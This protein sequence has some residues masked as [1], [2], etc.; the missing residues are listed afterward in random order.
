MGSRKKQTVGYRYY[1]G[2]HMGLARG[3]VDE[4]VQIRVG[5][6]L[7]W[8]GSASGNTT[9]QINRPELFGGD[10]REGGIQGSLDVL[11]GAPA[12]PV[13]AGLAAMLGGLVPAFRGVATLFYDGLVCSG[14]PYP[15]QW[16]VRLR[17]TTAGWAGNAP[18]YTAK[19]VVNLSGSEIAAGDGRVQAIRAA[20]PAHIL[21]ECLTNPDWGRGLPAARL[22][23]TAFRA[24]ADT[25]YAEG[26]GLCLRW[27]RSDKLAAFVQEILDTI[28]GI[29][30]VDR[31]SGLVQIR[32]IRSDYTPAALPLFTPDTGLLAITEDDAGAAADAANEVIVTYHSPVDNADHQVRVRSLGA[33]QAAGGRKSA[34]SQEYQGIPTAAL[35]LRVAQRDL[36]ANSG[37]LKRFKVQ[38]DRRAF[39]VQVGD[40]FRL[41][42]PARGINNMVVRAGRVEYADGTEGTITITALQDAF[43]LPATS[44]VTPQPGAAAGPN[45]APAPVTQQ[46]LIELPYRELVQAMDG[47]NLALLSA[48][49]GYLGC[50]AA[51]PTSMSM[52]YRLLTR[53]GASGPYTDRAEAP[54][55]PTGTLATAMPL[56]AAAITVTLAGG[57][58]LDQ[59][60]P[61]TA[62]L[63]DD[64]IL[65]VDSI[66]PSAGL[67]T[68]ARGCADTVPA[69]HA[70]GARVWFYDDFAG[71]DPNEYTATTTVQAK[72]L[73]FTSA[74]TLAEAAASTYSLTFAQRAARPYPPG[75]LKIN[76]EP[77]PELAAGD[78]AVTW[79]H[80]NRITQADQLID[81]TVGSITPEAGTSYTVRLH[82][83]ASN[84]LVAEYAGI[85]GTSQSIPIATFDGVLAARITVTA[86]RGGVECW[87]SPAH[88]FFYGPSAL[89]LHFVAPHTPD[90]GDA[91]DLRFTT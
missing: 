5:D 86:L 68:L 19:A 39:A 13:H 41:A 79:A 4:L 24:A 42:D 90:A 88:A 34:I 80:R 46:R 78:V 16:A 37:T 2:L 75:N 73:T 45:T 70:A 81:T 28:G 53:V 61:G 51:R 52:G 15:K 8:S 63:I 67:V 82:N 27:A 91:V 56:T 49:G 26:F 22:D 43:G 11:M 87:Q 55:A 18:W 40:V 76:G 85:T 36:V 38:L 57:Q 77:F 62:A 83:T 65:R 17:R 21:Y 7:A 89:S 60:A 25:L 29:I 48:T 1:F 50:I 71:A 35:A 72:A 74:G 47:A 9:L 20:N 14:S 58:L 31:A 54:F 69:A 12:Q 10:D 33:I 84:T 30:R 44:Y 6:K 59:V 32:L 23:D 66:T 3:P 64:E